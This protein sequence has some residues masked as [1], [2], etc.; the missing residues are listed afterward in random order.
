[1]DFLVLNRLRGFVLIS[2]VL[3][4]KE[5]FEADNAEPR[6][7]F[8]RPQQDEVFEIAGTVQIVDNEDVLF[9]EQWINHN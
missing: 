1:M 8:A 3:V 4:N 7:Y 6:D 5:D 9:H 2:Q